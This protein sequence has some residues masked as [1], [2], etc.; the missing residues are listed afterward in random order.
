MYPSGTLSLNICVGT[1]SV[2]IISTG[3]ELP[4][5]HTSSQR[6]RPYKLTTTHHLILLGLQ[7]GYHAEPE[8]I[9]LDKALPGILVLVPEY[10]RVARTDGGAQQLLAAL[11]KDLHG[12]DVPLAQLSMIVIASGGAMFKPPKQRVGRWSLTFA[13]KLA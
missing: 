5:E 1:G 12:E 11:L 8:G 10:L 2:G 3:V 9:T 6:C 13:L 4:R 7:G